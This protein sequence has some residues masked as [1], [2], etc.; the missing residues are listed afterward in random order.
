MYRNIKVYKNEVELL[1]ILNNCWKH[2]SNHR[3]R[4]GQEH[5]LYYIKQDANITIVIIIK[6]LN[7]IKTA[8]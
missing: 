3:H 2:N 7:T 8:N 6:K 4:Q 5:N 1:G